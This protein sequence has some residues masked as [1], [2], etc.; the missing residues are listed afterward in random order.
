MDYTHEYHC[1]YGMY[2]HLVLVVAYRKKVLNKKI[3]CRCIEIIKDISPNFDIDVLESDGEP[4]HLHLLVK[5]KPHSTI[6]K[7]VNSIKTVTSRY[8][9]QEFPE[10]REKLWKEKFWSGSYFA[11]TTGGA[12]LDQIKRYIE[13]QGK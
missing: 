11:A 8:L 6:S 5:F 3:M 7:F 1:V 13:S 9:K 10:I 2:C 12:P 4:D